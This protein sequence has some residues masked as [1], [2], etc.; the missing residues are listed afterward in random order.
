MRAEGVR[1]SATARV[2][3]ASVPTV[4][5][6]GKKG[7]AG[8]RESDALSS[9]A[10]SGRPGGVRASI[11]AFDEMWTCL[12]ARRGERRKDLWIWTVVVED[13]DGVRR[14]MREVGGRDEA[15]FSRLLDRLPDADRR[16]TDSY[17]VY[18]W[19]PRDRHVI[20]KGR[21]VNRNEGLRSKLR[22]KLNRLTRRAKGYT[23]SVDTL[24]HL[25]AIVFEECLNQ[26]I[27]HIGAAH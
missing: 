3:G 11:V 25:L 12:G 5:N 21:A 8:D 24:K 2:M 6:W 16:E 14:P 23:K 18:G 1:L 4:S 15:A 10:T 13:R 17:P 27:K 7:G 20:G 22:S 19:L 9:V 26:S